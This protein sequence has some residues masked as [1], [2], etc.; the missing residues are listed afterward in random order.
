M[1][2]A[3]E[4]E[5]NQA[6][7]EPADSVVENNWIIHAMNVAVSWKARSSVGILTVSLMHW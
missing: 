1:L 3:V 7:A 6:I 5:L 2:V 4:K